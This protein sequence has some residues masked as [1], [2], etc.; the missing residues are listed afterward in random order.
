[1][2]FLSWYLYLIFNFKHFPLSLNTLFRL[3]PGG[4]MSCGGPGRRFNLTC[5]FLT[6]GSDTCHLQLEAQR[7]VQ[8]MVCS[9]L[10][11]LWRISMTL[12][13]VEN[14]VTLICGWLYEALVWESDMKLQTKIILF[15]MSWVL[16]A[17]ESENSLSKTSQE[18][19]CLLPPLEC[20]MT[21]GRWFHL[22]LFLVCSGMFLSPFPLHTVVGNYGSIGTVS[23]LRG[24]LRT[25]FWGPTLASEYLCGPTPLLFFHS[26]PAQADLMAASLC[27][28]CL[29]ETACLMTRQKGLE[30]PGPFRG[31][32][33]GPGQSTECEER[34]DWRLGIACP[35]TGSSRI[36]E[37][38]K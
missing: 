9:P 6:G 23:C 8:L 15:P 11:C 17:R 13:R 37:C 30:C 16:Q 22:P 21:S 12:F 34:H 38:T 35:S 33:E 7:F 4:W 28:R 36:K 18:E 10:K 26:G 31:T 27:L 25:Y 14:M 29:R 19:S 1:M 2:H 24:S 3:G 20:V 5:P 32:A